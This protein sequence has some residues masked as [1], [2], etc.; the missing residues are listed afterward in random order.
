[1]LSS[2]D[3][4]HQEIMKV[5][6]NSTFFMILCVHLS[7]YYHFDQNDCRLIQESF[8]RGH[9]AKMSI[10]SGFLYAKIFDCGVSKRKSY[11]FC[12]VLE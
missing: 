5:L 12:E 9:S 4:E 7:T 11:D 2:P 1:M 6:L 10:Y 8:S 3:F